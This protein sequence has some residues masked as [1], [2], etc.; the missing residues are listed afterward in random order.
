M[1][2]DIDHRRD[3]KSG[4]RNPK[5]KDP[6]LLL[7]VKLYRFLTRRTGSGFN[8]VVSKR[9]MMSRV[10][11]PPVSLSNVARKTASKGDKSIAVVVG[12]VVSDPRLYKIPN[13]TVAALRFSES[14][15]DSIVKNGGR[16]LSLD[17]LA[18]E[19]PTGKNTVLIQGK[20]H[21]RE[22]VRHFHGI[23]GAKAVPYTRGKGPTGRS[24]E[25]THTRRKAHK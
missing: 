23:R 4:R 3:R 20:R 15:R 13:L 25:R 21:A 18:L 11:L 24:G 10:N 22:S 2:I 19:R 1:G 16:C 5:S 8:K 9:L 6:Y 7:L 14:A 17:Q 12:T